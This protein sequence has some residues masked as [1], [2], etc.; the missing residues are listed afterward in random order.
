VKTLR[1]LAGFVSSDFAFV[2][3]VEK[4]E[5]EEGEEE[6]EEDPIH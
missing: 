2:A 3:D 5:E 1:V 4:E 6:G